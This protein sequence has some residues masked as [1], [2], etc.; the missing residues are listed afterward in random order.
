MTTV[1]HG[2]ILCG[3]CRWHGPERSPT[4]P[5][6]KQFEVTLRDEERAQL[7]AFTRKGIAAAREVRR[8]RILLLAAE[9]RRD[10]EVADAVGCGVGT[11]ARVRRRCVEAGVDA[12]LRD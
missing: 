2:G 8:A 11:V 3:S 12:A 10:R 6:P 4:M 7:V 5:K 9:G 1:N